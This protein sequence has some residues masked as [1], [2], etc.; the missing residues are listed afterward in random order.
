MDTNLTLHQQ[1]LVVR[2]VRR[3]RIVVVSELRFLREGVAEILDRDPSVS[4]V[5]IC[6]DLHE[7]V[8]LS[9]DLQ[10]DLVLL[11]VAFAD[12]TAAVVRTRNIAPDFRIV[13]FAV[14]EVEEDII[15]WADLARL[16]IDIHDG[17]QP[18]SGRVAAGL[19][20]RIATTASLG[21]GHNTASP[22]FPLT[23]CEDRRVDQLRAQ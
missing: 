21:N 23:R 5:G 1:D 13:A 2:D 4:V 22:A 3:L 15:A 8:A 11:D 20:R 7:A 12:C 9:P 10:P 14:K 17:K 18:C 6:A 16:V 19:L